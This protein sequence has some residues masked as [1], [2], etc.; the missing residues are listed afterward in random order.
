MVPQRPSMLF[1]KATQLKSLQHKGKDLTISTTSKHEGCMQAGRPPSPGRPTPSKTSSHA[2]FSRRTSASG[3]QPAG[4]AATPGVTPEIQ[5][6]RSVSEDSDSEGGTLFQPVQFREHV[7]VSQ[8]PCCCLHLFRHVSG[9]G[10]LWLCGRLPV[11]L[12]A[13]MPAVLAW[14]RWFARV[15]GESECR[16]HSIREAIGGYKVCHVK[17]IWQHVY[18]L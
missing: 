16:T 11:C 2:S 4:P 17:C 1:L 13:C 5:P 6:A 18:A 3:G 12:S 10:C 15:T 7:Q 9:S 14:L 8:H